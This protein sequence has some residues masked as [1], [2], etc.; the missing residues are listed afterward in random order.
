MKATESA[1]KVRDIGNQLRSVFIDRERMISAMEWAMVSGEHLVVLGPPGTGKSAMIRFVADAAGL[2][3]CRRVLNPDTTREDLVGPIDPKAL[4]EGRWERCWAALAT[5]D[6]AFLDEIWKASSQVVNM[7]LD[8]LEERRVT[9]GNID[10]EIPLH[11]AMAASNET[12][13][14]E[15]EAM[16]DR[17]TI[18]LVVGY[19]TG[20]QDFSRLLLD[21]NVKPSPVPITHHELEMMRQACLDMAASPSQ[22][23]V[24]MLTRMWSG[25]S[26][27]ST[28]RV[29]DRR[30]KRVLVVA[31]ANAL[32][33]GRAE[34]ET[35]DLMVARDILWS[36]V[37]EIEKIDSWIEGVIDEEL[38]ALRAITALVGELELEAVSVITLE[39]R[40]RI[41]YRATKLLRDIQGRESQEWDGLRERL[42]GIR[43]AVV[44]DV[45]DSDSPLS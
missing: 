7:L 19:L 35:A 6:L 16:W 30:W 12:A 23:V 33:Q 4:K 25:V 24:E 36:R 38:M 17:F 44:V 41:S 31:A 28:E 14:D 43:D 10:M 27:V 9:S 34:I 45:D 37:D 40:G 29:S 32:L 13:S 18:R 8:A 15:T 26:G 11:V 22:S 5:A 3:F 2:T 21:T 1:K 20:A 42:S 39:D